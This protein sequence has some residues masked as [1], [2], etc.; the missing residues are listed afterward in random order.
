MPTANIGRKEEIEDPLAFSLSVIF[1]VESGFR[2]IAQIK[3][4]F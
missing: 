1:F 3:Q 4:P 2:L